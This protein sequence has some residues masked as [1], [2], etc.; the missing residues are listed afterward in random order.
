MFYND[1]VPSKYSA[2]YIQRRN[3]MQNSAVNDLGKEQIENERLREVW[4]L[5]E[6]F[7]KN[8]GRITARGISIPFGLDGKAR[9]AIEKILETNE[10]REVVRKI[11]Y[12]MKI[13]ESASK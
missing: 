11:Q 5:L 3:Y 4:R 2:I 8:C 12:E 13:T 9:R 10:G 6:I 1:F 7:N